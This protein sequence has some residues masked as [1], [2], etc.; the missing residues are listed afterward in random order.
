MEQKTIEFNLS[1]DAEERKQAMV[2]LQRTYN[3]ISTSSDGRKVIA[4]PKEN[5]TES[6]PYPQQY[7]YD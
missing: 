4:V 2:M 3:I 5:V 7:L 6:M 1:E